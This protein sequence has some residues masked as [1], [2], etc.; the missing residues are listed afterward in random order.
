MAYATSTLEDRFSLKVD[1]HD[2]CGCWP[3][4][5]AQKAGGYGNIFLR[6]E[7]GVVITESAHV[8]SYELFVGPVPPDLWVLHKCDNP[9]CIRPDHLFVGPPKTNQD[10]MRAKGRGNDVRKLSFET[11]L[12]IRDARAV[13]VRL[14]ILAEQ[15][16]VSE[17][18]ISMAA[19][20]ITHSHQNHNPRDL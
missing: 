20:G 8:V 17:G 5:G 3:W 16:G 4:L 13:G 12:A 1:M 2:L 7:D 6:K 14:R 15:Y 11:V 18:A 19:R 9:P 10:D